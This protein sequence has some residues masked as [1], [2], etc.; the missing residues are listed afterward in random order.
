MG[1]SA[2][3][4]LRSP[5]P[6][7]ETHGNS[8][9]HADLTNKVGKSSGPNF[10]IQFE[11]AV[12]AITA[13]MSPI[14]EIAF[15]TMKPQHIIE[16]IAEHLETLVNQDTKTVL[17]ATWGKTNREELAIMVV[18]WESLEV[19]MLRSQD[20]I[21]TYLHMGLGTRRG[22]QE[23]NPRDTSSLWYLFAKS[24]AEGHSRQ[25]P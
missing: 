7:G 10:E 23:S 19:R 17:G 6:N 14:V 2:L 22:R 1:G 25:V 15:I 20:F 5:V 12:E 8:Q 13:F 9:K 11:N 24:G 21:V 16:D 3:L 4:T 18:G